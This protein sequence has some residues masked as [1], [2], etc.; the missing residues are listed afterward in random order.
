[1]LTLQKVLHKVFVQNITMQV[2]ERH[3]VRGL[4][5][6]FS[7]VTVQVMSEAEVM[8]VAAEPAAAKRHR[9]YLEDQLEKLTDGQRI[10]K[11]V[12]R[13]TST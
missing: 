6:I 5:N 3:I 8:G 4:E 1:M 10:L 2:V 7:P 13:S 12:M 9:W 11:G